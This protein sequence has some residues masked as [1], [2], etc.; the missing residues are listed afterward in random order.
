V[1]DSQEPFRRRYE[2]ALRGERRMRGPDLACDPSDMYVGASAALLRAAALR[3]QGP[4]SSD[5]LFVAGRGD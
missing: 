2:V 1:G 4:G 5:L 3:R